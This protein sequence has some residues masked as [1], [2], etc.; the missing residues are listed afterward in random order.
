[1]V[2]SRWFGPWYSYCLPRNPRVLTSG[3]QG[4]VCV[5]NVMV[6]SQKPE[7]FFLRNGRFHL[8]RQG[9]QLSRLLAAEVCRPAVVM[10]D[11]PRCEVVWIELVTHSIRQFHLHFPSRA[12]PY[13]I[14]FQTQSAITAG[15]ATC[16]R[17]YRAGFGCRH[18][19]ENPSP[20]RPDVL[21]SP[22]SLLFN[23]CRWGFQAIL[24]PKHDVNL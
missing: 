7:S 3:E 19:K 22:H 10:L 17:L 16:Y 23:G 14:T 6:H 4:V 15:S 18:G 1:M 13:A 5:W 24:R 9:R 11:T 8:N 12:S 2:C 21:S 20:R